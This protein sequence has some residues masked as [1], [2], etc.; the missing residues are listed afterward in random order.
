[1]G[2]IV[3]VFKLGPISF[4]V[5]E[6][7]IGGQLVQPGTAGTA[8]TVVVALEDSLTVLGV[9]LA[10]ADEEPAVQTT[11]STQ[12]TVHNLRGTVAVA[13]VGVFKLTASGAIAFGD[14]VVVGANGTVKVAPAISGTPTQAEIQAN[15]KGIV[16]QCVEVG[17]IADTERGKI[18]LRLA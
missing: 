2:G 12:L 7:I 5:G 15:T 13:H 10:D 3:E 1:M 11:P 4:P 8:G 9:A 16:G 14:Y 6:P 18:K 17:G